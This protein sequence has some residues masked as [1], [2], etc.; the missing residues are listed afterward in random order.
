MSSSGS[1]GSD[2][3]EDYEVEKITG[4]KRQ[5]NEY[6]YKVRWKNYG[7]DQDTWEPQSNLDNCQ[8][9]IDEYWA[10]RNADK[11]KKR[12]EEGGVGGV[13]TTS[14]ASTT[15]S[16]SGAS[17]TMD[18][19]IKES[20]VVKPKVDSIVDKKPSPVKEKKAEKDELTNFPTATTAEKTESWT[21]DTVKLMTGK[22][23]DDGE[24][25]KVKD[26]TK[27]SS[28]SK[29]K[30]EV[31]S[32]P[33]VVDSS[34]AGSVTSS[35]P[36]K[37]VN[38]SKSA[39]K[40]KLVSLDAPIIKKKPAVESSGA[41]ATS[42]VGTD[43]KLR[44][45]KLKSDYEKL[46]RNY[47]KL[48]QSNAEMKKKVDKSSVDT[49]TA[50]IDTRDL[51]SNGDQ[52]FIE[53]KRQPVELLRDAVSSGELSV[54]EEAV[55]NMALKPASFHWDEP[56]SDRK[57]LLGKA[58][59][60]RNQDMVRLL[61]NAPGLD[62]NTR[63]NEDGATP[64]ILACD[65]GLLNIAS[66]LLEAGAHVN[67]ITHMGETALMKAS[68]NGHEEIVGLLLE[69]CADTNKK[70]EQNQIAQQMA[71]LKN[72]Q[73]CVKAIEQ[74]YSWIKNCIDEK[75]KLYLRDAYEIGNTPLFPMHCHSIKEGDFNCT[76]D[77]TNNSVSPNGGFLLFV[78]H[79]KIEPRR[80]NIMARL[81]GPCFVQ[82]VRMNS[83]VL[84]VPVPGA[85]FILGFIPK[86]GVNQ[87][88]ITVVHAP[89]SDT[90]L[91]V[92]AYAV[93]RKKAP[94]GPPGA[95]NTAALMNQ[96]SGFR[97]TLPK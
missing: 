15:T 43:Y 87:L 84:P 72:H 10:R 85:N 52:A 3:E 5:D 56:D 83:Q 37:P 25:P 2:D 41:G 97:A 35:K 24:K 44:F 42:S 61:L 88:Q 7:K 51:Y 64:L 70:S 63:C 29:P 59:E 14:A 82:Q 6:V 80:N 94:I 40:H 55:Y 1:D 78:A 33:S 90:K 77:I 31:K 8:R 96:G 16:M 81:H 74:H 79:C 76:V 71:R 32:K 17:K 95:F 21:A 22:D 13:Q 26:P 34:D 66:L 60:S 4:H 89:W 58:V 49:L 91:V 67:K 19:P 53:S 68:K 50:E 46:K 36:T 62:P 23:P 20:D 11:E 69:Y 48:N 18:Q 45:E 73:G 9:A 65:L 39:K 92:C 75:I 47:E 54:V 30:S 57:T 93:T 38:E 27:S 12:L 86:S 28:E